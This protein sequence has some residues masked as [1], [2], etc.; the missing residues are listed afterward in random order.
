[1]KNSLYKFKN[2]F[3][4]QRSSSCWFSR[5]LSLSGYLYR[6]NVAIGQSNAGISILWMYL[7]CVVDNEPRVLP[8]KAPENIGFKNKSLGTEKF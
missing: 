8:W 2:T 1:M 4:K 7:L 5:A 6:G 3:A